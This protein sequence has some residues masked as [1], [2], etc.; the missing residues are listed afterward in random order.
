LFNIKAK[1]Y[2][3]KSIND[4]NISIYILASLS[5]INTA[6]KEAR[7]L[8]FGKRTLICV[9]NTNKKT[10]TLNFSKIQYLLNC[11]INIFEAK[12]LLGRSN[13]RIKDKNLI[14]S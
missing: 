7:P 1:T 12:K 5:V 6:S 10:Y 14:I 4:F 2:I 3:A 11:G 13:I 8:G 9:I